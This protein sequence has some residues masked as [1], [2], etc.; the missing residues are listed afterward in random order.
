MAILG[1]LKSLYLKFRVHIA[2][3]SLRT[4]KEQRTGARCYIFLAADYGNL[5][6]VAIT[7]SQRKFLSLMYRDYEV[8]EVN[9]AE[10]LRKIP[11]IK[12]NLL[13]EDIITVVGGGN[14]GDMYGD[15]ELLRLLVVK[16][17]PNN[18]IILFPQ[19]IDYGN[20]GEAKWLKRLSLK[21]YCSHDNLLMMARESRSF[22]T[23]KQLYKGSNVKLVPDIVMTLNETDDN[24]KRRNIVTFCLRDDMEKAD[25]GEILH[26]VKQLINKRGLSI[27]EYDTHIDGERF[28]QQQKYAELNKL[29][30]QFRRSRLVVTD[31]LHGM[32]FAFI[33]G[34]PAIVLP[35][36]NFKVVGCYQWI[37]DASYIKYI[38]DA[39]EDID[40]DSLENAAIDGPSKINSNFHNLFYQSLCEK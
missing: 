4:P 11:E 21:I 2:M 24:A 20:S 22:E 39:D 9:A 35:N 29:W 1:R 25:N 16:N 36:S 33:T 32:I 27:E 17:F 14:M 6:D 23:M 3:A 28:T 8:V 18:R 40:L 37:K 5:G 7:L 12:R 34:T 15:I 30:N 31:R 10:T 38:T 26:H 19:T 13:V